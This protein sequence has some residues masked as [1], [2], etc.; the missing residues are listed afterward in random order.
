MKNIFSCQFLIIVKNKGS[1][2]HIRDSSPDKPNNSAT[3][4][5]SARY[6]TLHAS[7]LRVLGTLRGEFKP[8]KIFSDRIYR[9]FADFV[10]AT[11]S[12]AG[13]V[14]IKVEDGFRFFADML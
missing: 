13:C 10:G 9:I 12:A 3:V 8:E 2:C 6:R 14:A 5:N 1:D 4:A 7:F 11:P